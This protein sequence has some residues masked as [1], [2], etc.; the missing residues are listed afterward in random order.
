[1]TNTRRYPEKV[2]NWPERYVLL[3]DSLCHFNPVRCLSFTW[4]WLC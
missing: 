1:M 4:R 2:A 3:G